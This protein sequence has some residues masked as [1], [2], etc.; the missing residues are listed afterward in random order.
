[1][2]QRFTNGSKIGAAASWIRDS[3]VG[4]AR[5]VSGKARRAMV[6]CGVDFMVWQGETWYGEVWSVK[7]R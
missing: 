3:K 6:L 5:V 7:A 2:W 4:F 1:M